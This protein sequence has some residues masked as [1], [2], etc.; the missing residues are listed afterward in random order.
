MAT[1]HTTPLGAGPGDDL[2]YHQRYKA[3]EHF[4]SK[5]EEFDAVKI[6]TWLFLSTEVLLFSGLFVA[7]A[8]FRMLYPEA[9]RN[10]S[11]YLDWEYGFLNTIVLLISSYTV[12]SSIRNA[13]RD[14]QTK[15]KINLLI[16]L[17]CAIAFLAIKL[18]FEYWPKYQQGKLPG[19]FFSY[20]F[21]TDVNEPLWWAVYWVATGI[22]ASHVIVGIGL[23]SW[24]LIR[25]QKRH[26]GPTHYNAVEVVGLYWHIVDM[27]WIFL[28]P[29]LYL[30]H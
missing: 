29:L 24:L 18:I 12:A 1:I 30:I 5:E 26:F 2:P 21:A 27:V 22:H 7:Y 14:E 11:A 3:A 13:Q 19:K 20:P 8:I 4:R 28:F 25:A 15:L 6:G 23:L 10:G 16:T 9:F 17:V